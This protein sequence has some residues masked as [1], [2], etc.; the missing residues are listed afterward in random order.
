MKLLAERYLGG[1]VRFESQETVGTTFR[2][3]LPASPPAEEGLPHG[4]PLDGALQETGFRRI[5]VL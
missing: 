4:A 5:N 1:E 2:I 3:R